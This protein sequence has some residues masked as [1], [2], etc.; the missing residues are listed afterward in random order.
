MKNEENEFEKENPA[1]HA[2][3]HF[4]TNGNVIPVDD[5]FE[6]PDSYGIDTLF[7]HP[8]N[9]DSLFIYW[10]ITNTLLYSK[11][12]D[13][14]DM[15]FTVKIY[16]IK[17]GEPKKRREQEVYSFVVK[18]MVGSIYIK[19]PAA[20]K[21]LAAKMGVMVNNEFVVLLR[22]KSIAVPSFEVLGP[23]EDLWMERLKDLPSGTLINKAE[24]AKEEKPEKIEANKMP[25]VK[26]ELEIL[27]QFLSVRVQ[28]TKIMDTFVQIVEA[29]RKNSQDHAKV[30]EILRHFVDVRSK[31]MEL[32]RLLL[33]FI[34]YLLLMEGTPID[35]AKYLK[36][37]TDASVG[38]S[39]NLYKD[40]QV[41]L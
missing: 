9:N 13:P 35:I 31:D 20:L 39:E 14:A 32:L 26:K 1:N 2:I 4:V 36:E 37:I 10:E 5:E 19:Y 25:D 16:A 21:P 23:R 27:R 3:E 24:K 6:I 40:E 12:N 15:E 30:V 33:E 38:S 22:S 29:L 34:S 11:F 17:M 18:D 7:I 41:K 28:D 8:S